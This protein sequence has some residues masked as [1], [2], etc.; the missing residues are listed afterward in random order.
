[1]FI[2]LGSDRATVR[3]GQIRAATVRERADL[4]SNRTYG[5]AL[6]LGAQRAVAAMREREGSRACRAER[7]RSTSTH[8]M[9]MK[10]GKLCT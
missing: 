9:Q 3:G 1:M 7:E 4:G 5:V 10:F 6:S 8:A 2:T